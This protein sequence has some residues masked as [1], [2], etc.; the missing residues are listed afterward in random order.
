MPEKI[1]HKERTRA[2]ILDEAAKA[3]R[4]QGHERIGV[5][6]VMKRA[7]LTHGG[8]YAH[9]RNRDD[10]IAATVDRAFEDSRAMIARN[11]RPGDPRGSLSRLIDE[12]LSEGHRRRT[13]T[14]C[15]VA[16]L[17]SEAARMPDAARLRFEEGMRGM[18][19]A[20]TEA[21]A[22]LGTGDPE[23]V[24]SSAMAEMIGALTLSR[25]IG[26]DAKANKSLERSR[27]QLKRRLGL[28]A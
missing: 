9:F 19:G 11:F 17:G 15:P 2:R 8:F 27:D 21:L 10:L 24:A 5:A 13:G 4:E 3:L 26:D 28:I 16:A 18:R 6:D 20:I 23:A 14:G 7:G 22:E 1:T 25:A 12:Y